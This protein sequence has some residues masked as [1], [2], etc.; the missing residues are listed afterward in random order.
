MSNEPEQ[1]PETVEK[2]DQEVQEALRRD[3][4]NTEETDGPE[5][6]A[7][8]TAFVVFVQDGVGFAVSGLGTVE[9]DLGNKRVV[10]EALKTA[11][12][13]DMYRYCSEVAKDIQVSETAT[14]TMRQFVMYTQQMQQQMQNQQVAQKIAKGGGP[15]GLHVPGM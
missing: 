10:L 3:E 7:V 2:T 15:G 5:T 12:A 8:D 1:Q 9:V 6:M 4:M 13:G 11:D 14:Q